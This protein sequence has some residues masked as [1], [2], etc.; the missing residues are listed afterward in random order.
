MEVFKETYFD[1]YWASERG[2]IKSTRGGNVTILQYRKRPARHQVQICV[3]E[4]GG[5]FMKLVYVDVLV[6]QAWD[7]FEDPSREEP[8]YRDGDETNHVIS[9][10][11]WRPKKS[12]REKLIDSENQKIVDFYR[13]ISAIKSHIVQLESMSDSDFT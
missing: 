1:G 2:V 4:L 6:L 9:N 5:R 7:R 8:G 12:R 13:R 3:G 10:L 11:F